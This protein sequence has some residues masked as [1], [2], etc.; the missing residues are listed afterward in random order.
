M[1]NIIPKKINFED[2]QLICKK[3]RPFSIMINTLDINEQKC[4]IQGTIFAEK[5]ENTINEL[6]NN[7]SFHITIVIYG[8]NCQDEEKIIKKYKQ[9]QKLGFKN[10]YIYC[11]GLFEWLLLQDI[12][13]VDEFPTTVKEN[14]ILK[15]KSNSLLSI[16]MISY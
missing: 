3:Q 16:Q 5:E 4:L 15:Y 2:I 11:G 1:G 12:Y 9:L 14:D 6:I 13:G 10:I 7:K 8:K